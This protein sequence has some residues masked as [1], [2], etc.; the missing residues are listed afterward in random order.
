MLLT[1]ILKQNAKKYPNKPAFTMKMGY[2]TVHLTYKDVYT[3]SKKIALFLE[4]QG[5]K[6]GDKILLFAP[7]SPYWC[8]VF[9][10]TILKGY[11]IVPLNVQSTSEMI[12]TIAD[13]TESKI[14]IKSHYLTFFG[15]SAKPNSKTREP[16]TI[17]D[18]PILY[19]TYTP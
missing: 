1:K 7:N 9:W 2:R 14:I 13:Q 11:V 17:R 3:L 19:S 4:S 8:C 16:H 6:K 15:I 12:K 10:G 18:F 5:C